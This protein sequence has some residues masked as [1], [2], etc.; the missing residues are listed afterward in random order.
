MDKCFNKDV[1]MILKSAEKEMLNLRHPYVGTEHLL[2][3]L[4]K[5]K[6]ISDLCAKFKLT[7]AGFREA[8][9]NVIGC[10]SKKSEFILYTPLL[11]KVIDEAQA[12]ANGDNKS[13]DDLY[14]FSSL[15]DENDGIALRIVSS[16]G[17]DPK[18]LTK[19]LGKPKILSGLGICLNDTVS[20]RIYLRDKEIDEIISVLLRKNKNNPLLV[21]KAGTGKSAIVY[22]LARRINEGVVPD[23]LKNMKIYLISTSSL[24]AGTKYRGEF[25]EKINNLISEVIRCKNIILFID[26]I[27]TIVKTGSSEAGIDAANILKPYLARDDLKV[28]GATTTSEYNEYLKK[29]SAFLRRFAK[30]MINEPTNADMIKIMNKVKL[31]YEDY[32]NLKISKKVILSLVKYCDEYLPNSSNPD[33]CIDILDTTCSNLILDKYKSKKN[34]LEVR[35]S[36]IYDTILSRVN[37]VKSDYERIDALRDELCKSYN[38]KIVSNILNL[39]RDVKANRY[40]VMDGADNKEKKSI[41]ER[42]SKFLNINLMFFD[43]KDYSDEYGLNK[44]IGNNYLYNEVCDNPSS[45]IVF[46]NYNQRNRVLDN[47]IGTMINKGYIESSKNEKVFLNNSVVFLFNNDSSVNLGFGV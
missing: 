38:E 30:I 15:F 28:I 42:I 14:L 22:E 10:A 17:I 46:D 47:V 26:E 32:Y 25:E 39:L 20:D 21:G 36:D 18:E 9:V 27:H 44:F 12:R 37:V 5:R 24:V 16:M 3:A 35:D 34:V 33:K 45:L 43:C 19:E 1:C 31:V 8:L 7:Y 11:K 41:L 23:A 13:L 6:D 40:M 4:L 2:L 29:D